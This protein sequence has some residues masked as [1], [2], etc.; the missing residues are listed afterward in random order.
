MKRIVTLLLAAGLVVSAAMPSQAAQ[1]KVSG[2]WDFNFES[3][4][5]SF[6]N[7]HGASDDFKARQCLGLQFDIIAS[8]SLRGVIAFEMG[9]T[10]WGV[11]GD[12]DDGGAALGADGK[13]VSVTASFIDWYVPGTELQI[14]MGIQPIALPGAVA[15]SPILDDDMAGIVVSNAFSD[16]FALT[17]F[18]TR[19]YDGGL[20]DS[21]G[22]TNIGN[23]EMDMFGLAAPI[24]FDGHEITPYFAYV[25]VGDAVYEDSSDDES[26]MT[27]GDAYFAGIAYTMTA[28]DPLTINLDA[29]YGSFDG[30][31]S[32]D[33]QDG[34]LLA[35]SADY[36]LD[37]MTPGLVFWYASGDDDDDNGMLPEISG[38]F[39]PTTYGFDGAVGSAD[40][41]VFASSPA[42]TWG[43]MARVADITFIEDLTHCLNVAYFKGTNDNESEGLEIGD[44]YF[45]KDDSAWEINFDTQYQIYENLS[46]V[47]ELAYINLDIENYDAEDAYKVGINFSYEF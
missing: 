2:A 33:D 19:L 1:V 27:A 9:D 26:Q 34:W 10:S 29:I 4:D 18:W 35:V 40:S 46:M 17:A 20:A 38:A 39:A 21:D 14:R 30:D 5:A 16:E 23:D 22:N 11:G 45:T 36:A 43:I 44:T 13:V 32:A 8:E 47:V 24:T 25:T 41:A 3:S 12:T 31:D 7:G 28:F 6:G 15:G 42:G 37:M